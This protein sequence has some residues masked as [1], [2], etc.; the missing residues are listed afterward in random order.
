MTRAMLAL[1]LLCATPAA[2]REV[3]ID[4]HWDYREIKGPMQVYAVANGAKT[5]LWQTGTVG[6][7]SELPLGEE[8]SGHSVAVTPGHPRRLILVYANHGG[9]PA[10]FFAAPHHTEPEESALGFKFKCLCVNHA[11]QV[12]P[13]RFWYRVVEL[14]VDPAFAGGALTV[15]HTLIGIDAARKDQFSKDPGLD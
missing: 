2:A 8:L 15:S 14:R 3:A 12:E 13:G 7:L 4:L 11:Y 10:Y 6:A 1:L 5:V 9:A